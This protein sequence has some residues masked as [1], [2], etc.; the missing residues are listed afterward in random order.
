L[1]LFNYEFPE[2]V[3][4]IEKEKVIFVVSQ[5]KSK[6]CGKYNIYREFARINGITNEL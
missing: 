3:L 5:K 4:I 1:W 2:T 6:F